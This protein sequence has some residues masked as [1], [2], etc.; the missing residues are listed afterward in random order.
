MLN[1]S[2]S[3]PSD[4][5]ALQEF[6]RKRAANQARYRKR[7]K[8]D[9]GT[10][11][12]LGSSQPPAS[13]PQS[14]HRVDPTPQIQPRNLDFVSGVRGIQVHASAGTISWPGGLQ[15][16]APTLIRDGTNLLKFDETYVRH[17]ATFP[18]ATPESRYI[19]FLDKSSY[20]D[21]YDL[22]TAIRQSL[23]VGRPVVVRNFQDPGSFSL[24][25]D[26]LLREFGISPNMRV[27]MHG[28]CM[29]N[30]VVISL[31]IVVDAA[32]RAVDFNHPHVYGTMSQFVSGINNPDECRFVLDI[33]LTQ[34]GMPTSI[35]YAPFL[36]PPSTHLTLS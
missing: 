36:C 28:K 14:V 29:Y 5:E 18:E 1:C 13:D 11:P 22:V 26:N 15:T 27:D 19:D 32:I 23:S 20:P 10:P 21:P 24:V 3:R 34:R 25:E 4:P 30:L 35:G 8:L 12:N 2:N 16:V 31:S 6:R 9:A 7:Q 17:V 33:P